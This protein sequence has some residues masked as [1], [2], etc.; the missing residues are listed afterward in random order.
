[1]LQHP[2]P[3][4]YNKPA[5]GSWAG[6]S[7]IH[8]FQFGRELEYPRQIVVLAGQA[9]SLPVSVSDADQDALTFSAQG[10]PADTTPTDGTAGSLHPALNVRLHRENIRDISRITK[11]RE[12]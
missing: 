2:I 5:Y 3:N 12:I 7:Y 9:L 10:L 1:M 8:D 11:Q 6:A 4:G